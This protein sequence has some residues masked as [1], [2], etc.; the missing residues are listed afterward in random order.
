MSCSLVS[1]FGEDLR[2][3]TC[4]WFGRDCGLEGVNGL[5]ASFMPRSSET[6]C[7]AAQGAGSIQMEPPWRKVP[8]RGVP[9]CLATPRQTPTLRPPDDGTPR[10]YLQLAWWLVHLLAQLHSATGGCGNVPTHSCMLMT[11]S[12]H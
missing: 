2:C 1:V 10:P 9:A 8:A 5:L 6:E 11:V 12:T 7:S 3:R 4:E